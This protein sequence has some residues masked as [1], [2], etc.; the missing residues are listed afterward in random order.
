LFVLVT[1]ASVS[2][3]VI[4]PF[5]FFS[6]ATLCYLLF[7]A[8]QGVVL[9]RKFSIWFLL[10]YVVIFLCGVNDILNS[11][12]LI[13]STYLLP[14][15][16]IGFVFV[17]VI[18]LILLLSDALYKTEKLSVELEQANRNQKQVIFDRTIRL[19]EKSYELEKTNEVKDNIFSIIA[20]DLRAP[21][22]SLRAFLSIAA[23]DNTITISELKTHLRKIQRDTESL[24]L[25]LDNLLMWSRSQIKGVSIQQTDLEV[26]HLINLNLDLYRLAAENKEVKIRSTV[27]EGLYL[28]A[29]KDHMNLVLRNI[30]GNA[31]KFTQ[32]GGQ[33]VVS[34][35]VHDHYVQILIRDTGIGIP[36][37]H[38]KKIF[39]PN[40]HYTTYGTINE[41]GTGLGLM[42]CKEYITKNKGVLRIESEIGNG[43]EV[44][45]EIP[46]TKE[47]FDM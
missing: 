16:I 20:H 4:P 41:K 3:Y 37:E 29:D 17:N 19:S 23:L 32:S 46:A 5:L 40:V 43:T 44:C 15:S 30:I 45:I 24:N 34:S 12:E 26:A 42:L 11:Q 35:R 2:S 9:K 10:G 33:I 18:I 28:H 39:Q 47:L 21:I 8:I 1:P 22:K 27:P 31:L 7:I 38:L 13:Y 36:D 6:F 25:T 14:I